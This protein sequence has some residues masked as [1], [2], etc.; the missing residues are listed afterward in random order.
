MSNSKHKLSLAGSRDPFGKVTSLEQIPSALFE[1]LCL[2]RELKTPKGD[3]IASIADGVIA[4]ALNDP[5]AW[6]NLHQAILFGREGHLGKVALCVRHISKRRGIQSALCW[7]PWRVPQAVETCEEKQLRQ[8]QNIRLR[9]LARRRLP[10]AKAGDW[11]M[12]TY[13]YRRP[14][15]QAEEPHTHM[16]AD[17]KELI[18]FYDSEGNVPL[19]LLA[20]KVVYIVPESALVKAENFG[21]TLQRSQTSKTA[22][23]TK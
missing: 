1:I 20:S 6:L 16:L 15:N 5:E 13:I 2:A 18:V 14:P 10:R 9:D 19:V 12:K 23:L 3:Q 11:A 21:R 22:T 8:I 4:V 17:W 7:T